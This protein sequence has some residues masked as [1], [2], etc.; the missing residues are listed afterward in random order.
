MDKKIYINQLYKVIDSDDEKV[1]RVLWINDS[2]KYCYTINIH[3]TK[4]LPVLK[5]IDELLTEIENELL[6]KMVSDPWVRAIR[7]EDMIEIDK[8]NRERAWD[9]IKNIV[10]QPQ[11]YIDKER[12]KL[13][14]DTSQ[15]NAISE[16]TVYKYLKRYW[17]RGMNK[18][19]LLSDYYRCGASG[20]ERKSNNKKRGKPSDLSLHENGYRG[21]NV[22]DDM[23]RIF[24]LSIK[25]FY[26]S[27]KEASIQKVYELMISNFFTRKVTINGKVQK[28]LIDK[29]KIPSIGQF[30][31]W[32]NKFRDYEKEVKTRKGENR[33]NLDYRP[34]LSSVD[35]EAWGPG[36]RF[37]IDATIADVYLVNRFNRDWIIGRPVVYAIIDVFSRMITGLYIGLEGPSW[38]GA[39]MAIANMTEDKVLF[40]KQ[41][42]LEYNE[43]NWP[44]KEL[45]MSL[46]ADRGEME[47]KMPDGLIG[48]LN[49]SLENTAPYRGDL[50]GI[51]E[52]YFRTTN[53]KIKHWTPGLVKK[54]YKERGER[55]Y[56]LDAKLDIYQFTKIIIEVAVHH[57]NFK[58]L[59][60]YKLDEYMLRDCV[61]PIPIELWNWGIQN[62]SG[63][64]KSISQD[65]VKLNLM[66]RGKAT[67]LRGGIKFNKMFYSCEL[68]IKE[69]WYSTA[70][71]KGS[72][73]IQV[74]YDPRNI[75]Y[76]YI[77]TKEGNAFEKCHLLEKN[78]V[79][80]DKT[81]E[82]IEDR[83]YEERIKKEKNTMADL[84]QRVD[85]DEKIKTIVNEAESMSENIKIKASQ[86]IKNISSNK[87]LEREALRESEKWEI[88]EER[89]NIDSEVV[90]LPIND[91]MSENEDLDLFKKY[92]ED[93]KK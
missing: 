74:C 19:A 31:Y 82:E 70:E 17:Q 53:L 23:K 66:P 68:A 32:F 91:N 49:V 11:I 71:L 80:K 51:V 3:S 92:R 63:K 76:I 37:H 45:P 29:E 93:L 72:W 39:M 54:E 90:M 1:D 57:N 5:R 52:Q 30:K 27:K 48:Y 7:E 64:L 9:I 50:K 6:I 15:K 2:N 18:N 84:Q 67:I 14:K 26:E 46:L 28:E 69:K 60:N 47:G 25:E 86:R 34:I 43:E 65:V 16:K 13:I 59:N 10:D 36:T 79:Y 55:D 77:P 81:L 41:Y 61:N 21:L 89:S 33:Y 75:N 78:N 56:R 87:K 58:W 44:C 88:G 62:K 4:A 20:N 22:D 38:L 24:R 73:S 85:L 40:C 83:L 8:K 42:G 35:T 12:R